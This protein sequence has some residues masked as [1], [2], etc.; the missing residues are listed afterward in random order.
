MLG[1]SIWAV[2]NSYYA[3]LKE[4]Q[5][6]PDDIILFAETISDPEHAKNL[7]LT[8]KASPSPQAT[9]GYP[10]PSTTRSSRRSNAR[11]NQM[12]ILSKPCNA[13]PVSS[14]SGKKQATQ[15]HWTSHQGKRPL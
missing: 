1:R 4:K 14:K 2:L 6:Y 5:Y 13:F 10:Q 12:M 7:E 3:M 15:W 9:S 11:W 8:K